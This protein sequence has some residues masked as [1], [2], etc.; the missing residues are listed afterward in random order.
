M[1]L[2]YS[3]VKK[4]FYEETRF[5]YLKNTFSDFGILE[6]NGKIAK[7]RKIKIFERNSV[8]NYCSERK[9]YMSKPDMNTEKSLSTVLKSSILR[10][11]KGKKV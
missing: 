9:F 8:L 11:Y 2:N 1:V 4:F 5:E 3:R 10:G 6:F 7:F